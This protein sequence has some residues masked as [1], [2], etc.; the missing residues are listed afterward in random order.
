LAN[1]IVC[2]WLEKISDEQWTQYVTSSFNSI[3]ET[4]LHVAAAEHIW[5][6]RMIKE[7]NQV[8]LQS[9]FTGTKDEHIALWK[10]ASTALKDFVESLMKITCKRISIQAVE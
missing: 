3:Q 5:L 4:A 10:N 2:S 6:Q 9:S 8:W 1:D 7:P